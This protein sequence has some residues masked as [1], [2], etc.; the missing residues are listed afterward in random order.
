MCFFVN[1]SL[2]MFLE[3]T[4]R[5]LIVDETVDGG[6]GSAQFARLALADLDGVENHGLG[7]Y[8]GI[9]KMVP[10]IPA[11]APSTPACELVGTAPAGGGSL[12]RQR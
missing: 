2:S 6:M 9:E 7:I 12:N 3:V 10:S 11:M 4:T 8:Q 5:Q 1:V